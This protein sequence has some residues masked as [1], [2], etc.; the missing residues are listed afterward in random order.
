MR[1]LLAHGHQCRNNQPE[2]PSEGSGPTLG[3]I[4]ERQVSLNGTD[5]EQH[6]INNRN[7]RI[8]SIRTENLSVQGA[9][10]PS[11]PVQRGRPSRSPLDRHRAAAR[12]QRAM[13]TPGLARRGLLGRPT[14]IY[15]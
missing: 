4:E 2:F 6:T 11:G 1:E 8:T 12:Q 14:Q 15:L 10:V 7:E 13:L 5:A 9:S 3:H